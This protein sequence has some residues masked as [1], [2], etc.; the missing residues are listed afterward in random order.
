MKHD[1]LHNLRGMR[2]RQID[3]EFH[4]LPVMTVERLLDNRDTEEDE[5][6]VREFDQHT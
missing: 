3:Q 4:H 6:I 5:A 1:G 2:A